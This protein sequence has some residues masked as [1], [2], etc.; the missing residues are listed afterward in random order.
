MRTFTGMTDAA[1]NPWHLPPPLPPTPPAPPRRGRNWLALILFFALLGSG[2]LNLVLMATVAMSAGSDGSLNE[3]VVD[4]EGKSKDKILLI[5]VHGLLVQESP[6]PLGGRDPISRTMRA[7]ARAEKDEKVKAVVFDINSPGGGITD[8]DRLLHRI[9]KFREKRPEVAVI[10]S[11]ND[12]AASGGYYISAQ[13]DW[14]FAHRSTITAS[15]G[16]IIDL[17]NVSG[18]A[19][20]FGVKMEVVKSGERKD[21]GSPYRAMTEEERRHFDAMIGQ[22]Y[23]QFLRV[24]LAGR[25][26]LTDET[27][28]PIAD[29]NVL[30]GEMALHAGLVDAIGYLDDAYAEARKRAGSPNAKVVRYDAP[31]TLFELF[32]SRSD[33]P[34]PA[35]ATD[36]LDRLTALFT[37][38]G[39]PMYLWL[40]GLAR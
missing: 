3:T 36:P 13:A 29:G 14:I 20:K 25:K 28:R 34:A 40:P 19:E 35:A 7:L 32:A 33:A 26:N 6:G 2:F 8:C 18:L 10:V 5:P 4:G 38:S 15:I 39:R 17:L 24:V 37:G 31:V 9:L 11:M 12:V 22:M 16:V 1:P 21:I 27:L 23:E 30:T